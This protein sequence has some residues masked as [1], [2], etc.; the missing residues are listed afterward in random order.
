MYSNKVNSYFGFYIHPLVIYSISSFLYKQM[1][2]DEIKLILAK[3]DNV[4]K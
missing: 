1:H 4:V 3:Y 2:Q